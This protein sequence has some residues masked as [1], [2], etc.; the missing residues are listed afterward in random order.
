MAQHNFPPTPVYPLGIDSN[1]TLY[2]VNNTVESV[3]SID[4]EPWSEEI[5]IVPVGANETEIWPTN[6]FGNIGGELF[7]YADVGYDSNGKINLL[8]R[9]LRNLGG[10]QTQY[11]STIAGTA[12]CPRAGTIVRGMVVAEHHN[13]LA[14]AVINLEEFIGYN[15]DTDTETL[16]FRI[17]CLDETPLC[18][19]D[20]CV[21]INRFEINIIKPSNECVGVDLEYNIDIEGLYTQY[22]LDF[23]DG[24]FTTTETQGTHSYLPNS[25]IDPVV[26]VTDPRCQ[27][28]QTPTIRN[29]VDLPTTSYLTSALTI[30][31]PEVPDFPNF[32]IP[33]TVFLPPEVV[34]PPILFPCISLDIDIPSFLLSF[35]PFGDIS[36]PTL[37]EF[38]PL[39]IPSIILFG[40][41]DIPSI[42]LFGDVNI[43]SVISVVGDAVNFP[44]VILFGDVNIPSEITFSPVDIPSN[45]TFIQPDGTPMHIP[46]NITFVQPD[47]TPMY[48]PSL[49][50][51]DNIPSLI[52]FGPTD[53][54]PSMISVIQNIP[55]TISVIFD[56]IPSLITFG[57][58]DYIPSMISVIQDIPE[59]ITL[60]DSLPNTITLTD[61]LPDTITF[62]N[63]PSNIPSMIS[64]SPTDIPEVISITDTLPTHL[65]G[66]NRVFDDILVID[67]LPS[68]ISIVGNL[69]SIIDFGENPLPT[70]IDFG[71]NHLPS[72]IDFEDNPLPS[73]IEL[74]P[75]DDFPIGITLGE[76]DI[77][78]G[79]G[80]WAALNGQISV[81]C[82]QIPSQ[83]S[84]IGEIPSHITMESPDLTVQWSDPPTISCI[85]TVSCPGD[86]IA[87]AAWANRK[88]SRFFD[89]DMLKN[90]D[91]PLNVEIGDLGIPSTIKVIAPKIPKAIRLKHNLPESIQLEGN[92]PEKITF[93]VPKIPE[94]IK[95]VSDFEI[96]NSIELTATDVPKSI[97]LIAPKIPESI[98]IIVPKDFPKSIKL[99]ASGIPNSIKVTGIPE[100]ITL[101]H[102]IPDEIYL[103][104]PEDM[105]VEMVYKGKPIDVNVK[106]DL[107]MQ[108]L[109]GVNEE[110]LQCVAIVPCPKV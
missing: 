96:P 64:F 4:N 89:E 110:E 59:I 99:D 73:I 32:D 95:I 5:Y 103:K 62:N 16:D 48:I 10:E 71:E 14:D 22:K 82:S 17:R 66:G 35:S 45:I 38:G 65:E 92:I 100:T 52:T 70:I 93:D 107:D 12:I 19:D 72:I 9:A 60:T 74:R 8:K 1:H 58:T 39:D 49:I 3:L 94:Q 7:Y 21:T 77:V 46:S 57:P 51:F 105:E 33:E 109:T 2:L 44:S 55:E 98:D 6:G 37:I 23:G 26:I 20:F 63:I 11:N 47:G 41:I 101:I 25:T 108:K 106:I 27:V 75:S 102:N 97:E 40:T 18:L 29:Q 78:L 85:V 31:I 53:Y 81:V 80:V 13:Q 50:T 36:I 87:P 84:I 54:I 61:S 68:L 83:I 43:P 91:E 30:P 28:V 67:N 56:S 34:V 15:Y 42:I 86:P 90:A 69:P 79:A 104:T 88:S 76:I 24:T